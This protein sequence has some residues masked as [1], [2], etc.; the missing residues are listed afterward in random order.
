MPGQDKYRET[1]SADNMAGYQARRLN[2]RVKRTDGKMEF[3][4]M[5]DATAVAGRTLI[6]IIENFQE[7]DGRVKIPETL[8]PFMM[9]KTHIEKV[10]TFL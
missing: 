4:H 10:Q 7:E 5:N 9:G 8:K 3:V 6:A 1:H 2:T